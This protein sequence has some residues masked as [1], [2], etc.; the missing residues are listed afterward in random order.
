MLDLVVCVAA[1]SIVI[2]QS[3]RLCARGDVH[4]FCQKAVAYSIVESCVIVGRVILFRAWAAS[5]VYC[6]AD[7]MI[8]MRSRVCSL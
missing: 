8:L 3:C 5:W 4:R 1:L 6:P 7:S 2:L